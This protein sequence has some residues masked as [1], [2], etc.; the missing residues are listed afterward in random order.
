[1][2]TPNFLSRRR[3]LRACLLGALPAFAGLGAH[4]AGPA[5]PAQ[6]VTILVPYSAGGNVDVLARWI[7]PDLSRRLGQPVVIENLPGA[8]GI[9]GTEKVV[10]AKPDGYTLLMSVESAVVIAKMVT[11]ATVRYDGLRDLQPVTLLGAQ[12]LALVGRPGLP[13]KTA[14]ELFKDMKDHPGKYSYATS[15]VGTSLHLGGEMLKQMAAVD[16]VHVPYRN[17]PQIVTDLSGNQLDLAV[18]PLSMVMQQARAG[19]VRIYGLMDDKPS[20]AMPEAQLLG[21]N[22]AALRGAKVTVWQGIFAPKGTPAHVVARLDEALRA[23]LQEPGVRRNFADGGVT[24]I[25]SGP[26]AFS[27]FLQEEQAKFGAVVAKGQIRAE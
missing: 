5:W 4:A 7:V 2:K 26:A 18:L 10:R 21:D 22:E 20:T 24:V 3:W 9:I 13:A 19:Q 17:G 12:P 1:M 8:G 15:G 23:V 27:R 6:P 25:G 11:P 16:M 14:G